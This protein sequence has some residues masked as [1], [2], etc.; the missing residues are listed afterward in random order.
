[1]S[2]NTKFCNGCKRD[3]AISE[4]YT[5]ANGYPVSE[6]KS[7]MKTRNKER[8]PVPKTT[9]LVPSERLVVAKLNSLGIPACPG[10]A[11]SHAHV[12]VVA[13]GLV[14]IEVKYSTLKQGGYAFITTPTQRKNGFRAHVVILICDPEDAPPTF[15]L[16]P[17]DHPAFYMDGRMKH[18][19]HYDPA[20]T[21][22]KH[23][24]NRVVL[25]KGL[26]DA[27]RDQWDMIEQ[28]RVRLSKRLRET[29]QQTDHEG[30]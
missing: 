23:E 15:H 9:A 6:C 7:C 11:I 3:K 5:R 13:W 8:V 25:T 2:D 12:D 26:M 29:T 10:K 20:V 1:M 30:D 21:Q 16:F 24:A 17:N 18:A 27:S 28:C 19:V 14:N 22:H 4:F